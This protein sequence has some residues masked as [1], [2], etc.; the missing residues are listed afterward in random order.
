MTKWKDLSYLMSN[1]AYR[2]VP[3]EQEFLST[4]SK[5]SQPGY[6]AQHDLFDQIPKLWKDFSIPDYC[7]ISSIDTVVKSW[8][9]PQNTI[10]TMHTD[11]KHNLLCQVLGEKLLIIASPDD[12]KNLYPYEGLLNNTSQVDPENLD[13]DNFRLAKNAKFFKVILKASE[14]IYIPKLWFHYVR[15]LSPSISV[16]FW[17]DVND[18]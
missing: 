5:F 10:S 7:A 1:A 4:E 11:N 8:I 13:F 3:I 17:F 15:S 2:T 6:L 18:E 9:G 16:S 14:M 12:A